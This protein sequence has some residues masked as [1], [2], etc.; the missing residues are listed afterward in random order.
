MWTKLNRLNSKAASSQ[1]EAEYIPI[2]AYKLVEN[3]MRNFE[4]EV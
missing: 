2:E 1:T 3:E 4:S